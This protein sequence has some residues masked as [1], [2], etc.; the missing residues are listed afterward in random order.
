MFSKR[1]EFEDFNGV[2]TSKV[3]YFHISKAE[4]LAM[5]GDNKDME[6][7]IQRIIASQDIKGVLEE[8]RALIKMSAGI[9]SEDGQRF[10]KT[11][12]AQSELFDSPA[13]DELLMEVCTKADA[14]AEFVRQLI[15][16]KMQKEMQAQIKG[17]KTPD[18]FAEKEDNR[19]LWV[20]EHRQPR[21]DELT[22]M[23]K[24]ELVYAMHMSKGMPD[25]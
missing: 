25:K 22:S 24:E 15:P 12:E 18:P 11:P 4:F 8:F 6:A 14:S 23:S 1:I 10:I 21:T 13:Y 3:F 5:T 7:R 9:R 16:E 20:R 17:D 19:P 2:K